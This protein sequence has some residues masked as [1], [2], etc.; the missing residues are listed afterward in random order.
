MNARLAGFLVDRIFGLLL[1]DV[2]TMTNEV[3]RQ[4]RHSMAASV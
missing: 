3:R 1:P 2:L 4:S